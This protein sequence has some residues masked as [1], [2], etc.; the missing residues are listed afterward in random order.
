MTEDSTRL[1]ISRT[2]LAHDRTL[3][4][5][6]RTSTSMTS[7]GFTI[8]TFFQYVRSEGGGPPDVER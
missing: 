5:W 2:I 4:A 3:M 7:F 8:Y 1:A 6:V